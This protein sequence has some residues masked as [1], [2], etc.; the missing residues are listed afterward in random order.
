MS[1]I[2]ALVIYARCLYL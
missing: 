2:K 1:D